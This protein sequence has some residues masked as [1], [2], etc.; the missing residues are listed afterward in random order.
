MP[1]VVGLTGGIGSGKSAVADY[2]AALGVPTI[3]ADKSA[4]DVVKPE[5]HALNQIAKHF[6]VE[7]INLDSTLNRS[8]LREAI[9]HNEA[10]RIWLENLLHPLIAQERIKQIESVTYPYV[11]VEIPL[12]L[13][14]DLGHEVDRILVVDSPESLQKSRVIGRDQVSRESV[15]AI[16]DMQVKADERRSAADDIIDNSGDLDSLRSQVQSLHKKYLQLAN[17]A[18]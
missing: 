9:F 11:I 18:V 3:S 8:A 13:E 2:F 17:Q 12:L 14:K 7:V 16:M 6:G 10:D 5:T 1:L 15:E 4:R